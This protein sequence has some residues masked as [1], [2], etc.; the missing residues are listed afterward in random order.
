MYSSILSDSF[1]FSRLLN[2]NNLSFMSFIPDI[3]RCGY[4][5]YPRQSDVVVLHIS[6]IHLD[7]EL[8]LHS[9]LCGG[10]REEFFGQQG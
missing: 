2:C 8:C 3:R 6:D 7:R 1:L 4:A 9:A 10:H 5:A